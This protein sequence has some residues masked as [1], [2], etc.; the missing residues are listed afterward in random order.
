MLE[1]ILVWFHRDLRDEDNVA[2]AEATRRA[3]RVFCVF[4]FDRAILDV[5]PSRTDRRVEFIHKSLQELDAALRLQGGALIVRYAQ[6]IDE[7]S[8]MLALELGI[9]RCICQSRF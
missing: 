9:V 6:A 8:Q 1:S 5:L 4:I 7:N 3:R 2:L